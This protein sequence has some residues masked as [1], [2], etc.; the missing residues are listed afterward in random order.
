MNAL[1]IVRIILYVRDIQEVAAFYQRHF[2]LKPMPGAE[3]SWLEIGL[4]NGGCS[5][6]L[7]QAAASQKRGAEMMIVF[8]VKDMR[9]FRAERIAAGLK[10]GALHTSVGHEFS[11]TKDPAG[12]SIQISSRGLK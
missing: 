9:A 8:G 3:E 7:H 12:N 2:G 5:I 6:A 11:N 1:P 10:F 4:P